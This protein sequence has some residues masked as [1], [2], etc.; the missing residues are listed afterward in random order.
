[1][2]QVTQVKQTAA[3]SEIAK[4]KQAEH[5]SQAGQSAADAEM[6]KAKSLEQ[7]AKASKSA[8]DS[9]SAHAESDD[10]RAA[11][12]LKEATAFRMYALEKLSQA[13]WFCLI[14]LL[15]F[16]GPLLL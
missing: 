2:E 12:K 1:M 13:K 6:T 9:E 14:S 8:A 16:T 10:L 7:V 15:L 3:E 5:V 4:A 11:S